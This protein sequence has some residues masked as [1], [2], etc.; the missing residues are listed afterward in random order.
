MLHVA[1]LVL[2]SFT[3][4]SQTSPGAT[5]RQWPECRTLALEAADRGDYGQMHDLAWRAV[6]LGPPRDAALMYLLARAQVLSGRPHDA[7]VMIQ[8]LAEMGVATDAA[9]NDDFA[10]TRELPAWSAVEATLAGKTK[11]TISATRAGTSAAPSPAGAKP[12]A[13]AASAATGVGAAPSGAAATAP[14]ATRAGLKPF[15][16]AAGSASTVARFSAERF[17]DAGLAYDAVS[18]RFVVGDAR[19]RKL[20]VVGVDADHA[21]DMVRADSAGF[22]DVSALDIDDRRG[23]LWVASTAPSGSALHRLQLVSGRPLRT[24][25]AAAAIGHTAITD[26]AV[27]R[28]GAI[29]ALDA[30]AGR[31]LTLARDAAEMTETL[32]LSLSSPASVVA[33]AEEGVLYV[34][35]SDGIARVDLRSGTVAPVSTTRG[36]DLGRFVRIRVA[37]NAIV[38]I[39]ELPD[40]SL[41]LVRLDLSAN[42]RT[43]TDAAVIDPRIAAAGTRPFVAV[44][45]GN[46]YYLSADGAA[47]SGSSGSPMQLSVR[48]V[49]VR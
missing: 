48:R 29:I 35:H 34:A 24:Y 25:R 40:G 20:M 41:Q 37:E 1:L 38:G 8:R 13:P 2:F 15:P 39:Q 36:F 47:P 49:R 9:T 11:T 19:E 12:A 28:S 5:C 27:A 30:S 31:L 42:G 17:A 21:T 45:E 43:I 7:L 46:L 4:Q 6:Q 10:R 32:K 23:D 14:T 33:A 44:S 16:I 26:L 3:A 22:Q 18:R